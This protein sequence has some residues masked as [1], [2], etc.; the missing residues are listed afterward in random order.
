[1]AVRAPPDAAFPVL[2]CEAA[3]PA[4]AA[5][6]AVEGTALPLPRAAAHRVVVFGD[7][8]CRLKAVAGYL[9]FQACNDPAQWPF[10]PVSEAAA[11][12]QPDLV[13]H[14][15]DYQY[16]ESPCPAGNGGCAGSPWGDD[17]AAWQADFFAPAAALRAAAPWV[18]ARGNHESCSRAGNGYF[19]LLDPRPLEPACA[20]LTDPYTVTAGGLAMTVFDSSAASDDRAKP[21]RVAAYRRQLEAPRPP[22]A[23]FVT[24]RPLWAV[25]TWL[26]K[27]GR[28]FALD[29]NATLQAASENALPGVALVLAGHIHTFEALAFADG[30]APQLVLGTGGS[31]LS[32]PVTVPLAGRAMAGTTVVAGRIAR[33]FG[34]T[35]LERAAQ[36]WDATFRDPAGRP[37]F[38]CRLREAQLDCAR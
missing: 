30:R 10:R 6:A 34:F 7:T 27:D 32:L 16:R 20:D 25:D 8:G 29:V 36:G 35:T 31:A 26:D 1:M 37:R 13:V 9:E 19:R 21:E 22:G 24:H 3:V 33:E 2:V 38:T 4:G 18:M 23:W 5:A 15:G 28:P 11:A 12:S 17:W 14:I